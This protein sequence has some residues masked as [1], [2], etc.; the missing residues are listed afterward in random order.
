MSQ[1]GFEVGDPDLGVV[2]GA[3][4]GEVGLD[5][6]EGLSG[7]GGLEGEGFRV[8]IIMKVRVVCEREERSGKGGL[9]RR[10]QCRSR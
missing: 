3:G 1:F 6:L 4:M 9:R 8:G 10:W 7:S 2:Q 5:E